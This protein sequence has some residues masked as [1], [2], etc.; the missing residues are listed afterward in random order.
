MATAIKIIGG[1]LAILVVVAIGFW[2]YLRA[3]DLPRETVVAKY[4][5]PN[6]HFV[7]LPG[8]VQLHYLES[9]P[10]NAPPLLLIHGFGDNSFSW[11]GWTKVLAKN[12]RV[13]AI[14][15]PGHGLT[16][17]PIDF[18]ASADH[19]ADL[20]DA[21][22]GAIGL[23]S[24]AVAGNSM[25]GGVS[26][27]LALRHPARVSALILVDAAGWPTQSLNKNPP[28][29]FRVMQYKLGRDLLA[30]IDNLPL[31]RE[32][33]KKDVVDQSV[34]TEPFIQR[35]ADVQRM[36]GHRQ[37][38]MSLRPGSLAASKET[39]AAIKAPT[40][41]LWGRQDQLIE[42]G[43]AYRFADAIPGSKMIIYPDAGHLLMVDQPDRSALDVATFLAAHTE[44]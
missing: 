4:S 29:A 13:I 26:W 43:A 19:Y 27:Q 36:P 14:D 3:P 15:L 6:S 37:I 11:D 39:L 16:T 33:L 24:F 20:V 34:L 25:G 2:L 31:I 44:H 10:A 8:G 9:G 41:I 21:F 28:L 32:G 30:S 35:W 18:P 17:S 42:V 7:A 38:L 23:K 5:R 1:I 22:A 12:H 40:L